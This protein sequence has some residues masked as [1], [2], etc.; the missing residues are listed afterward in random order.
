MV[1][2]VVRYV[3]LEQVELSVNLVD[4]ADVTRQ[5]EDGTDPTTTEAA[6]ARCQLVICIARGHHRYGPLG[7]GC[8]SQSL[9]NSSRLLEESLLAC[10]VLFS[11]ISTHS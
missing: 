4:Q 5:Q 7:L 11:E 9:G 1:R 10:C 2:L 8:V 6:G 3:P